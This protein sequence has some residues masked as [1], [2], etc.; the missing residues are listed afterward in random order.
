MYDTKKR[1]VKSKKKGIVFIADH[2]GSF[3][4]GIDV[5]NE[6]LCKAMGYVVDQTQIEVICLVI[7]EGEPVRTR[8]ARIC[9]EINNV[10]VISYYK[11]QGETVQESC[12]GA[13]AELEKDAKD[14]EI[15]W[16][17]G[18]DIKTGNYAC[19]MAEKNEK[20]KSA[21]V[22]HTD[23]SKVHQRYKR[24]ENGYSSKLNWEKQ[25]ELEKKADYTFSVG[26]VMKKQFEEV[27]RKTYEIIPGLEESHEPDGKNHCI[28]I[29]GRF[30]KTEEDQKNWRGA[31]EALVAAV[32]KLKESNRK[33]TD[34]PIQF[35]GFERKISRKELN[36]IQREIETY[37][38]NRT[39]K[40]PI[41]RCEYFMENREDYLKE[42]AQ[43]SVLVMAS[44]METFGMTAWEALAMRIPI[45]IS[46]S[47]GVYK[48]LEEKLGYL[49]KGLCGF[50]NSDSQDMN[51]QMG[52]CI[53]EILI[54]EDKM[55]KATEILRK[56]MNENKW[57]TVAIDVANQM[58]IK[59]VMDKGIYKNFNCYEFTY[60]TRSLMF[61][62]LKRRI[63]SKNIKKRIL[64]F[65]G[66][67]RDLIQDEAFTLSLLRL[68]N[69][70]GCEN[71]QV[72]LCYGISEAINQRSQQ[73]EK[74]NLDELLE[75]A[76]YIKEIKVKLQE[77]YELNDLGK[78]TM[79]SFD[80]YAKRIHLIPLKKSPSVYINILDDDWYFTQKFEN[81]TS[82]NTTVKIADGIGGIREKER[83]VTHMDFIFKDTEDNE[84]CKI[85]IQ[86]LKKWLEEA[87]KKE[88]Q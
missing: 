44:E 69:A 83:M 65:E 2:W 50:F 78:N 62:D 40:K 73:M 54:N 23:Y 48:H 8:M 75:K 81:R 66:V 80:D 37:V 1:K 42:V 10:S 16:F 59:D 47:S 71:V 88:E 36:Q 13:L 52:E 77:I 14:T 29:T 24:S 6:K 60:A 7:A 86:E 28:L 58:G 72:Y 87:K 56:E 63:N 15:L 68:L 53:A 57:E 33:I 30:Y 3:M 41:I 76:E 46:D 82:E 5:F 85:L 67:S 4:G 31:C 21:V 19:I 55:H 34:F 45:V 43:S 18:H 79:Q 26:P 22:F 35:I 51:K 61:E 70:K 39:G 74:D 84:E 12:D 64:F 11:Q 38:S 9:K 25:I 32:N 27:G 17:I 20:R 49:M